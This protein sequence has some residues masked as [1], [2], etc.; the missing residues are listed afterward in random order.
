[1]AGSAHLVI[2]RA[3]KAG[4]SFELKVILQ[5]KLASITAAV[6]AALADAAIPESVLDAGARRHDD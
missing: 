3:G 4:I 1:M 2:P 6:H 5:G